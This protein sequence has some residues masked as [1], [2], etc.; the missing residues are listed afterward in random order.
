MIILMHKKSV[1][2]GYIVKGQKNKLIQHLENWIISASV[3]SAVGAGWNLQAA[4][5][6]R[7]DLA[8]P[9]IRF[10]ERATYVT[11]AGGIIAIPI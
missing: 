3:C 4:A 2:I 8:K 6:T 9:G 1:A 7:Q 5:S 11:K 10:C